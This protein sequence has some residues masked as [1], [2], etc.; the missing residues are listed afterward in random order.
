MTFVRLAISGALIYAATYG[1]Q[2][3][4]LA[5]FLVLV[6]GHIELAAVVIKRNALTREDRV[7]AFLNELK[8]KRDPSQIPKP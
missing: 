2:T 4:A 3:W 1:G 5:L 8:K 7:M 6:T